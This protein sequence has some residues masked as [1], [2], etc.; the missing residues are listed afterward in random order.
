M[1]TTLAERLEKV[2]AGPPKISQAALARA[3]NVKPPSISDWLSGRTKKLEGS[4][5]L[6]AAKLLS[7]NPTWLSE[8][9]GP[10]RTEVAKPPAPAPL[11]TEETEG[12]YSV[13]VL[14]N[15][16]SM[17]GGEQVHDE[18][19]V[20]RLTLS[21]TWINR[22]LSGLSRPDNLRFIHGYGDSMEPTFID[23]D[24]LLVDAGIREIKVDGIYVLEAN[25]RLYIKRVR[26]RM[27]ASFEISSD[28]ATVKTVDVLDGRN[29]VAVLG[30][31]IWAWNGRKL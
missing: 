23:G 18:V 2:M 30:R 9:I 15:A 20:G 4:N 25:E 5:L 12:G 16:G 19:V 8:G 26:Q 31:V 6:K 22:S 1:Q 14:A 29:P 17:G 24:I 27:D 3:C 10:M 13:P 7:V 28:N 11:F 21:P